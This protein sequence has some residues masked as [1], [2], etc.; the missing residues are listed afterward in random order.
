M[1]DLHDSVHAFADGELAPAEAEAFRTHLGTCSRCQTELAD[2][3]Q[4]QHLGGRLGKEEKRVSSPPALSSRRA[5]RPV[6]SRRGVLLATAVVG[7]LAVV[8]GLAGLRSGPGEPGGEP[9]AIAPLRTLEARLSYAGAAHYRP[10]EVQRSG[11]G[12]ARDS[13]PLKTLGR[14]EEAGDFHGL[15]ALYLLRGELG[16][17]SDNLRRAPQTPD[18]DSDRAVLALSKGEL[19]E[20]LILIEQVLDAQPRHP[21]AL[22]NRGLVLHA[23]GLDLLSAQS[24]R[25]VAALQEPGWSE[26]ARARAEAVEKETQERIERWKA[27]QAALKNLAAQGTP[28]PEGTVQ[29]LPALTRKYLGLAAWSAP[30]PERVLALLPVARTLDARYGGHVLEEYLQR[31]ARRDFRRRAPLAATF[32]QLLAGKKLETE[33]ADR[34]IRDLQAAGED[35]IL[36]GALPMLGRMPAELRLYESAART[37]GDPWF[38]MYAELQRARKQMAASD[39]SRA[40]TTL[41]TALDICER[42]R[43]DFRCGELELD[44]TYLYQQQHRLVEAREHALSGMTRAH[45]LLD[46]DQERQFIESLAHISL[47]R[48]AFSLARAYYR[49][50][51]LRQPDYCPVQVALHETLADLRI[52]ELRPAEARTEL[53]QVPSCGASR[54]LFS[55]YAL[56]NLARLDPHP[57]DVERLGQFVA[58][59]RA[60]ALPLESNRLNVDFVEAQAALLRDRATGQHQLRWLIASTE[61][62]PPEEVTAQKVRADAYAALILDAGRAGEYAQALSLFAEELEAPPPERCVLGVELDGERT[63]VVARGAHGELVGTFDASRRTPAFDVT[64]LVPGPV[65]TALEPCPRVRVYARYPIHGR[66]ELLPPRFAWSYARGAEPSSPAPSGGLP[67]HLVVSDVEAPAALGLPRLR[68]WQAARDAD[69]REHLMGAAATPSR[70]LSAMARADEI[71]IHAHGLVNLGVSEASLIVLAPEADGR[72]A[73]TAS[74]VRRQRLERSPVVVLAAC[75]AAQTAPS[76]HEPWS[77][78]TAFLKAGARAVIASPIDIPDVQAGPFFEAVRARIRAGELPV[79]AVRNERLAALEKDPSS[80]TRTV[81]VFE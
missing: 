41:R 51:A 47:F 3:L 67:R 17:A 21:Q 75:R 28:L 5:F 58:Q 77:L 25:E 22:W 49:E 64:R 43:L 81:L 30:T 14:M 31:T 35:D 13:V 10:Y 11:E 7:C 38:T 2:I 79:L 57:D 20:A 18:A 60:K 63:L 33:A 56:A 70:V 26:E 40:E 72:Y 69:G 66:A 34:F 54:T 4:L 42:Q 16:Q 65:L 8:V 1:S 74:E 61:R 36:L 45:A 39:L 50:S 55:A 27:A 48:D 76:W 68:P 32:A 24:F 53:E 46:N 15:A 37:V 9:L 19:E 78:P 62:F 52:R 6:W 23:L 44:L 71:D 29:A 12:P 59:L 73:L 80:W